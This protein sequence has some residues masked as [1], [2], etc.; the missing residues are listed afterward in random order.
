MINEHCSSDKYLE[1]RFDD[2]PKDEA[3]NIFLQHRLLYRIN[4]RV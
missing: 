2:D 3:V 4:L 1:T